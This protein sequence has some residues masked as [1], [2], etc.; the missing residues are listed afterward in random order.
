MKIAIL[1][2]P[3]HYNYG[4]DLQW[5]ALILTLDRLGHVGCN[6]AIVQEQKLPPLKQRPFLYTKRFINK[7]LGRQYSC[8]F[9][10]HKIIRDRDIV[11]K[12]ADEFISSNIP[13][14]PHKYKDALSLNE[15]ND[16]EFD[17]IIVG[18]DQVWRPKYAFP[19]IRSFFLDFLKN[20]QKTLRISYAASFGTDMQEYSEKEIRDCG[21]L[22]EKFDA[23]SVRESSALHLINNVFKWKCPAAPQLVLDPTMLLEKD[24][25]LKIVPYSTEIKKTK[26]LF[27]YIL[28]MTP[29]KKKLIDNIC[30]DE[31][32]KK[33]TVFPKSTLPNSK[34]E[35]KVIPPV[36]RWIQGF[37]KAAIIITDSFHGCVFSII[38][39]KPFIVYANEKRGIAR[40]RSL[41][42]MFNLED[43]LIT[44]SS[45]FNQ[46]KLHSAIDCTKVNFIKEEK[47]EQSLTFL[48]DAL[49]RQR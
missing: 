9:S 21:N 16:Y 6:I 7:I 37:N 31:E 17:A 30:I 42:E 49:K 14:T 1:T 44:N 13:L 8:V 45:E 15:L 41:L 3:L 36:E 40:F 48:Q 43:R 46:A 27:Y 12:Y 10:E 22:I 23:V 28:D 18:S 2:L 25:Y 35:D 39:N 26:E 4:G 11:H 47:K 29:D 20:N 32:L 34:V 24:E 38:F 33:F 19:D 5:Y